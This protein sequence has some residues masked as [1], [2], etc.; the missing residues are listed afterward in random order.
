M[1]EDSQMHHSVLKEK[2]LVVARVCCGICTQLPNMI[3]KFQ[4][5]LLEHYKRQITC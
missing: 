3:S 5:V 2:Y 1:T 4:T